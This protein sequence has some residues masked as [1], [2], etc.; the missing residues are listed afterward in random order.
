M[1]EKVLTNQKDSSNETDDS[2]EKKKRKKLKKKTVGQLE[3]S[4]YLNINGQCTERAARKKSEPSDSANEYFVGQR[5]PPSEKSFDQVSQEQEG[6]FVENNNAMPRYSNW[7]MSPEKSSINDQLNCG[8]GSST[9]ATPSLNSMSPSSVKS[10]S[11][12]N[13]LTNSQRSLS[14]QQR[15]FPHSQA[16]ASLRRRETNVLSSEQF[17]DY[18][19]IQYNDQPED[20]NPNISIQEPNMFEQN[21]HQRGT[22]IT[23]YAAP[24][25]AQQF[26]YKSNDTSL[27]LSLQT[28]GKNGK[29]GF[30]FCNGSS[31]CQKPSNSSNGTSTTSAAASVMAAVYMS[32]RNPE[33]YSPQNSYATRISHRSLQQRIYPNY[34][35]PQQQIYPNDLSVASVYSCS[36]PLAL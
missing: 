1:E 20:F 22:A 5:T 21:C 10:P 23:S 6:M 26:G 36:N 27:D 3:S 32:S 2:A 35:P 15:R 7:I 9:D 29:N 34:D 14:N 24:S 4:N 17:R 8:T 33:A 13:E 12:G 18:N 31:R 19:S 25:H 16:P 30:Y 28:K 11:W